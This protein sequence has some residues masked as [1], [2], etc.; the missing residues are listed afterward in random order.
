MQSS[1]VKSV[2]F[3]QLQLRTIKKAHQAMLLGYAYFDVLKN[4]KNLV[5]SEVSGCQIN[6]TIDV[7]TKWK[8]ILRDTYLQCK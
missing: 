3:H 4:C 6:R 5:E 7:P 1:L 2:V 8:G